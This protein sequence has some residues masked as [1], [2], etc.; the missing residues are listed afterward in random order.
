MKYDSIN[1]SSFTFKK[2]WVC[3][4]QII[5]C[6]DFQNLL[7]EMDHMINDWELREITSTTYTC[8]I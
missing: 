4:T 2:N 1:W 7:I 3:K 8:K 5:K 6:N